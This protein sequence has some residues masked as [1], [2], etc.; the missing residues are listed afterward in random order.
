MRTPGRLR[1]IAGRH[2]GRRIAVPAEGVRPTPDRVREAL[3][4]ILGP[5]VAGARFADLYAGTGI[6][7]LEAASRGAGFVL[8]VEASARLRRALEAE[9]KRIGIDGGRVLAGDVSGILRGGLPGGPADIAFADP[10]F[11]AHPGVELL[12]AAA[13]GGA[14]VE[15]GL[16]VVE[17]PATAPEPVEGTAF[18]PVR[19]TPYGRVRLD[20]YRARAR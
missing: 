6:V 5:R 18:E 10:P 13:E 14:V 16:L 4:S 11:D 8:W 9:V 20:F 7:G 2:R 1:I 15:R 19:S 12:E 3:F 17:T